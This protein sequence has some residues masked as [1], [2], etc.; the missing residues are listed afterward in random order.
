MPLLSHAVVDF[1][2]C[3]LP[4]SICAEMEAREGGGVQDRRGPLGIGPRLAHREEQPTS[5]FP[6]AA[7]ILPLEVAAF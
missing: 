5:A 1:A 7:D 3:L 6:F 2:F 4:N